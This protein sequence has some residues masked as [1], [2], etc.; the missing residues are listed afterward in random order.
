MPILTRTVLCERPIT[1]TAPDGTVRT[2]TETYPVQVPRDWRRAGL[3]T[4]M[5]GTGALLVAAVAWSTASIGDLLAGAVHP[6]I[7]YSAAVAFDAAWIICMILEW[8]ARDEPAKVSA[9]RTFGFVALIIAMIAV[10]THGYLSAADH[11]LATGVIGA[12][13]SALAKGVWS[14]VISHTAKPLSPMARTWVRERREL[15]DAELLDARLDV[16]LL[17]ARAQVASFRAAYAAAPATEPIPDPD[18]PSGRPA[19]ISPT[20]RSAVR[21]AI[22]VS[23]GAWPEDIVEQ[24]ARIGI[25]TDADTVRLLSGQQADRSD[26]RSGD[27]LTLVPHSPD[28][29]ITDTVKAAV[30]TAG[31]DLDAVL[32]AV[33]RVHGPNVKRDTVRRL[34]GR[35]AG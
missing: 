16:E 13:I 21:A 10:C 31:P 27:V 11:A 24:L 8:L 4:A 2:D 6:V 17:R 30:R 20:V 14:L 5:T 29:T 32:S 25:E 26:S 12:G 3:T 19:P 22:A 23:P 9:P 15:V 7:A 28:D 33:R 34:L 18:R 1:W 35:A